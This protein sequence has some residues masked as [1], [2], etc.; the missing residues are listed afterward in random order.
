[1]GF[2]SGADPQRESELSVAT[3]ALGLEEI[4]GNVYRMSKDQIGCRLLQLK[5]DQGDP[6]FVE[7]ICGEAQPYLADM[8]KDPFGNYLFQKIVDKVDEEGRTDLVNRV[9]DEMVDAGMNLHG[10][11]SVQK[12]IE[13]CRNTPCQVEL[14]VNALR[15]A[16]VTLCLDTN[17]NHVVQRLLQHLA[18]ADNAFVFEMLADECVAVATH[19]H[20]CCVLQR[21]ID[22]ATV[23]QSRMLVAQVCKH[24]LD[25]MQ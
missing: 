4:D 1:A 18:P 19:R 16:T 9:A 10:T 3:E 12:V 21:A 15:A 22:A 11:R 13:V 25:L 20:G 5:L 17:G 24:A 2:S 6:V 8:M 7:K 23:D 14:V